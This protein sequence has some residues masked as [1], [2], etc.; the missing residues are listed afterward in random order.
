TLDSQFHCMIAKASE[1]DILTRVMH[2]IRGALV[3]QS[4]LIGSLTKGKSR[5]VVE[6]R[7][8]GVTVPGVS[9]PGLGWAIA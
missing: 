1:N 2:D 5:G 6:F 8:P 7:E 4:Q 9:L 3:Q